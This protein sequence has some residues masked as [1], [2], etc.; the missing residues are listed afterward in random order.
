MTASE[1]RK[2]GG[3]V[4]I[5]PPAKGKR[6]EGVKKQGIEGKIRGD[7]AQERQVI[8]KK[9]RGRGRTGGGEKNERCFGRDEKG[10][11]AGTS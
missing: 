8:G 10:S 1:Q 9:E 11:A 7:S 4:G 5:G 6:E 3:K 2:K